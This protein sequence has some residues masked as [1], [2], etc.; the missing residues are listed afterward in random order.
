ME[1]Y[2]GNIEII[3]SENNICQFTDNEIIFTLSTESKEEK[4]EFTLTME[5]GIQTY[6]AEIN[7]KDLTTFSLFKVAES[8][9]NALQIIDG[10]FANKEVK[11]SYQK[12]YKMSF[13]NLFFKKYLT[14]ELIFFPRDKN[15]ETTV[16]RLS[17]MVVTLNKENKKKTEE[18]NTLIANTKDQIKRLTDMNLELREENVKIKE[19]L[20][21]LEDPILASKSKILKKED[22]PSHKLWFSDVSF[23]LELI[24]SSYI[25]GDKISAFTS[26]CKG[27]APTLVVIKSENGKR[28]G[29]Y[30]S[31]EWN[32][33]GSYQDGNNEFIFSFDNFASYYMT[34][35]VMQN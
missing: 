25:D 35:S 5:G 4:I 31:T 29:G 22:Y 19:R 7:R 18:I 34:D 11:I 32:S 13:F 10:C 2:Q 33:D 17:D 24:Y 12:G 20:L 3:K 14:A 28:F 1:S 23:N 16:S 15:L 8:L 27:I 21:A 9:E 26:K 6:K 30:T